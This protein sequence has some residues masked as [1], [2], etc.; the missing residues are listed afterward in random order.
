MSTPTIDIE[1]Q[2]AEIDDFEEL[3]TIRISAMR[4][5]LERV[6]RFDP[7]RARKRLAKDFDIRNTTCFLHQKMII[8]FMVTGVENQEVVIRHLYVKPEF[9]NLGVGKF[10][11]GRVIE[12]GI[13]EQRNIRLITLKESR[14][15][16]FYLKN[17]FSLDGSMEFDNVYVK[18]FSKEVSS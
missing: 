6:G 14:A 1:F 11:L 7:A 18:K 9:Q 4:E 2:Q 15:N 17:G 13:Q 5:S 12:Q 10:V 3:V 16:D 8:G